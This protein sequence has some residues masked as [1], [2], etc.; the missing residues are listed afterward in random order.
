MAVFLMTPY[1]VRLWSSY[2][3]T[4]PCLKN[5]CCISFE[6][7]RERERG[8][9]RET[10]ILEIFCSLFHSQILTL[11]G[12]GQVKVKRVRNSIWVSRLSGRNPTTCA[13]T[14]HLPGSA[15]TEGWSRGQSQDLNPETQIWYT[16]SPVM[17][18][19][20]HQTPSPLYCYCYSASMD[21]SLAGGPQHVFKVCLWVSCDIPL[22]PWNH[23]P[24]PGRDFSHSEKSS[25]PFVF[26]L[27]VPPCH[28]VRTSLGQ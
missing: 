14:C 8:R 24:L 10:Y 12:L 9:E 19:L 11:T 25:C 27:Q 2:F 7:K 17:S 18:K 15:W 16:V 20:L 26:P 13:I 28:P 5:I 1:C 4:L 23:F 21:V 3:L 6:R 22:H